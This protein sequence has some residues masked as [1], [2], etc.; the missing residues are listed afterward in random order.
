[1]G[2]EGAVS[3]IWTVESEGSPREEIVGVER[4]GSVTLL[5]FED[6]SRLEFQTGE[7]LRE[8]LD[9]QIIAELVARV[10]GYRKEIEEAA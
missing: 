4:F 7:L 3:G 9:A 6:G 2:A 5:I 10:V 1:M 8:L